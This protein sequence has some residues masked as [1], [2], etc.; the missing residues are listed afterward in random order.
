MRADEAQ[1]IHDS[2][3]SGLELGTR[4]LREQTRR[5]LY[6]YRDVCVDLLVQEGGESLRILHGHLLSSPGGEP[7]PDVPVALGSA[8][9]STDGQG[10]FVLTLLEGCAPQRLELQA[11]RQPFFCAIPAMDHPCEA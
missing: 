3:R 5:M 9:T 6:R 11:G 10:E 4:G 1:L 8:E 7:V 2:A